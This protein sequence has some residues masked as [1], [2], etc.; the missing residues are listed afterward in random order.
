VFEVAL[1]K[2][3]VNLFPPCWWQDA[4]EKQGKWLSPSLRFECQECLKNCTKAANKNDFPLDLDD[5]ILFHPKARLIGHVSTTSI[6]AD[7]DHLSL[8]PPEFRR[9]LEIMGKEAGDALPAHTDYD[10][11]IDL[12]DGEKPPWG[13]IYPLSEV[14]LATLREWLSDM[15][16]TGKIR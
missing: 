7:Q 14:E 16:R 2:P 8:V 5:S 3:N 15:L 11:R 6:T 13:P 10:H 12:K 9:F 1:L 4:H